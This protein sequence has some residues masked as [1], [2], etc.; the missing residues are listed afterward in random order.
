MKRKCCPRDWKWNRARWNL[1]QQQWQLWN[2]ERWRRRLGGRLQSG[3][4]GLADMQIQRKG[5][6]RLPPLKVSLP[7]VP[8][9]HTA[10]I[11]YWY[12]RKHIGS[13]STYGIFLLFLLARPP[14]LPPFGEIDVQ[15][16][17]SMA[18]AAAEKLCTYK[19]RT[20]TIWSRILN[21]YCRS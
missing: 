19:L 2:R 14:S 5:L 3:G 11:R 8:T 20:S 16:L 1:L 15:K 12:M 18:D 17:R 4:Y 7:A 6:G 9:R 10:A 21:C 13:T